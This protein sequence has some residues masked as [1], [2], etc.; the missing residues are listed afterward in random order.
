MPDTQDRS[1]SGQMAAA[2]SNAVVR[3][4]NQYTGRGPTKA[5]TTMSDDLVVV[6]MA[7]T[8]LKAE[9]TLVDRGDAATVLGLRHKFQSAMREDLVAAVEEHTGRKVSAFLSDNHIDPDIGV[10]TFVLEP[11]KT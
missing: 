3:I 2:I 11:V 8:L 5:R 7:D 10:E 6:V 1:T 9:R 4:T